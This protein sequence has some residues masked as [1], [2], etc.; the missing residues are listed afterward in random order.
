M[1]KTLEL[2]LKSPLPATATAKTVSSPA[3]NSAAPADLS[4]GSVHFI[5]TATTLIRFAG[6]TFITDPNFLHAGDHVHLGYGLVSK[7]RTNP[8]LEIDALPPLDFCLLS[9]LHG[10]H[11]DRVAVAKLNKDLPLITTL[12]SAAG[13][14]RKGFRNLHGLGTWDMVRISK[15]GVKLS[16][17]AL[18][19]KHAPGLLNALLP[20][21]MGSLLHFESSEGRSLLRIYISGDTLI[22]K[23]LQEIPKR[24]PD[25]D[26]ALLHLGGTTILGVM[27]TMDGKQGVEA[28]RIIR[29]KKAIPIHYNDYTVFKSPLSDFKSEVEKAGLSDK[30]VYLAHGESYDFTVPLRSAPPGA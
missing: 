23:D 16:L 24:F 7:R 27:V 26:L 20:P 10:D 22:F 9:H 25:I 14:K 6:Y 28:L 8:A 18:P 15:D 11:F 13:L 12:H 21:V 19:G 2:P 29:P 4:R 17:T 5:G 30:V 3:P 1:P